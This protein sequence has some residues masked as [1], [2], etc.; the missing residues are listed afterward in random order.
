[1]ILLVKKKKKKEKRKKKGSLGV[2]YIL[3][4]EKRRKKNSMLA[5]GNLVGLKLYTIPCL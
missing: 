5:L 2:I 3:N 1:L 4:V